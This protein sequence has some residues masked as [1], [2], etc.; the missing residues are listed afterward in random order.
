M[1]GQLQDPNPSLLNSKNCPLCAIM[2]CGSVCVKCGPL[3]KVSQFNDQISIRR[4]WSSMPSFNQNGDRNCSY[5]LFY[6]LLKNVPN[7]IGRII[8]YFISFLFRLQTSDCNCFFTLI[9]GHP[10]CLIDGTVFSYHFGAT[11]IP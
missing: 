2:S 6:L 4:N 8:N 1:K 5:H 9:W 10:S 3:P 7:V 11:W